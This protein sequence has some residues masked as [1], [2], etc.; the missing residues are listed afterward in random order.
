[1]KISEFAVKEQEFLD[2]IGAVPLWKRGLYKLGAT[3][4]SQKALGKL[5][6]AH[7]ANNLYKQVKKWMGQSGERAVSANDLVNVVSIQQGRF[8]QG[9]MNTAIQKA[10]IDGDAKLSMRQ[11][12]KVLVGYLQQSSRRDAVANPQ[13][14]GNQQAAQD[15]PQTAA[16]QVQPTP[17]LQP[18]PQQAAPEPQPAA[19]APQPQPA[20]AAPEPQPQPAP[21]A[22]APQPQPAPAAPEPQPQPAPAAP[23]PQPAAPKP[24]RQT[25]AQ[26][27]QAAQARQATQ[28]A[29][30]MKKLGPQQVKIVKESIDDQILSEFAQKLDNI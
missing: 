13:S 2:E 1:M 26:R 25:I 11:L 14:G 5:D 28:K 27:G 23:E 10:G 17:Q 16:P 20:P 7:E 21:A 30:G 3:L 29:G 22:P 9:I 24:E 18:T 6:V 12:G 4:G 8:D 15:Q 19:P